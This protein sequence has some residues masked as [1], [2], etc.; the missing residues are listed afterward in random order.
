MAFPTYKV[1]FKPPE[2]V[3]E[4]LRGVVVYIQASSAETAIANS[5][6]TLSLSPEELQAVEVVQANMTL[7]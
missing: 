2:P 7:S 4:E 3:Q 6:Q 1:T 5:R